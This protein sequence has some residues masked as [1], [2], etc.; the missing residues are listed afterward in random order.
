GAAL[1]RGEAFANERLL[2]VDENRVFGAV[3]QRALGDGVDV[4]LVVL[5]EIGRKRVGDRAVLAHPRERAARVEA[6][7]ERDPD[8]LAGRQGLEYHALGRDLDAHA[9]P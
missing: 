3:F 7:A 6:A 2:S 9:A 4:R 8:P 1:Q 5:T